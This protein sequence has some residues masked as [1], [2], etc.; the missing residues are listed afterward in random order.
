MD[1]DIK[2]T[3]EGE[4]NNTLAFLDTCTVIKPDRTLDITI[5][6]KPTHTDQYLNFASNHP[7]EH[8][9]GVIQTLFHRAESVITDPDS[10]SKEK[11]HIE[12]ALE[13]CGYPQW[14]FNRI[15]EPKKPK[16]SANGN[17]ST[18]TKG[19]VVLPY[20]KGI[21]E[22]LRRNFNKYGIRVCFKPTR[23]LR[24]YLV[25]PKDK[26]EKKDINGPVYMIPC[27][28]QT[29][30]GLCQESYI[31]ETERSLRTRFLEHKR[32]SSVS[33]E[34]SQHIHYRVTGSQS[35]F[36]ANFSVGQRAKILRA[37]SQGSHLYQG[38]PTFIEP[39]RGA[40][41]TSKC[42]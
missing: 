2:F 10:V 33:S 37:W 23:T 24:Q 16:P 7:L 17:N 12:Q 6:R 30:R 15:K 34:V 25:S 38:E 1:P 42:L 3:T 40:L 13:K 21:S 27:Q 22:A 29:T 28:G 31:G 20:V 18:T 26:T 41:Q 8:K 11:D 5:Y 14:A 35:G 19:Q 9:L 4:E 32:P 36:G 39:R